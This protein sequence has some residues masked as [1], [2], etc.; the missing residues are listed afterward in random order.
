MNTFF[1]GTGRRKADVPFGFT[2]VE[3]LVVIA[4]IGVLVALIMPA[5]N[6][7]QESGRRAQC[8]NNVRTLAQACMA[9]E[10]QLK[11]FPSG[12]WGK[13]WAGNPD[14]GFGARAAGRLAV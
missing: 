10:N 7:V 13:W 12:G 4:I 14:A 8:Q 2:L 5:I 3:L 1:S 9:H 6:A 11:F